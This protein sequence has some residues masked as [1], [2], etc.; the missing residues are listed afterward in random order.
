MPR[1]R[2]PG[3][4]VL[5]LALAPTLASGSESRPDASRIASL[6]TSY[7]TGDAD[8]LAAVLAPEMV[9]EERGETKSRAKFLADVAA[10]GPHPEGGLSIEWI[11]TAVRYADVRGKWVVSWK[12]R[13]RELL[14]SIE[15]TFDDAGRIVRWLDDFGFGARFKPVRADGR[16]ESDHFT[17]VFDPATF[18]E[19]AAWSLSAT[20]ERYYGITRRFLGRGAA[21][22][23]RIELN[24]AE[25]HPMPYASDPGPG[26]YIL[27]PTKMAR[28]KYGFSM[29]HEFTH[30]LMGL[31]RLS[32]QEC[33][34]R[35][36][37]MWSGNRL[38]D[39]G[40]AVYVEERLT[41]KPEMFPNHGVETHA[42]YRALR[43]KLEAPV[44]PLLEVE[45]YRSHPA[46]SERF[47]RLA[48][49]QNGSF[50][51]YL[52]ETRGLERFL[53]LFDEG[54]AATEKIYGET[55]DVL[56]REWR[57]FVVGDD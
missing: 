25:V 38:L 19:K 13:P 40:F 20:A 9:F 3:L 45:Y 48:F 22:A 47:G 35:D 42:A 23:G 50:C 36:E 21:D 53:R 41:E 54:L 33:V 31:S 12:A 34:I 27:V 18:D 55:F 37:T 1:K 5:V 29:V 30:N 2:S 24:V 52:V 57:V 44:W 14:F 39:E 26:A 4:V 46:Q 16:I 8:T 17:L 49:L 10:A 6:V 11:G 7:H 15:L 51:K 28:R 56:E 32:R 43:A